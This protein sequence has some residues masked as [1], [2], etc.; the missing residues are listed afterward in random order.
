MLLERERSRLHG[1]YGAEFLE[2]IVC[3]GEL[4]SQQASKHVLTGSGRLSRGSPPSLI[5]DQL[6]AVFLKKWQLKRP[7]R[8]GP[9]MLTLLK[10]YDVRVHTQ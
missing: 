7:I 9:C 5:S 3:V 1:V 4:D 2:V 8:I 10:V 6:A